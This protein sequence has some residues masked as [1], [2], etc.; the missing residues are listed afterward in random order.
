MTAKNIRPILSHASDTR[1]RVRQRA[2]EGIQGAFPFVGSRYVVD[3]DDVRVH[4][5]EFSPAEHKK[6]L[7]HAKTMAE[8]I[9]GTLLLKD[10]RTGKTIQRVP[11][12]NLLQLPY[13]TDHHTFVIDGNSYTVSNQLRM[14]PGVY[15]RKRRNEDLEATFNLAKGDNFRMS[16]DPEKGLFNVE[17][18]STKIP[19]YSV[20]NKMGVSDREMAKHWNSRLVSANRTAVGK[21]TDAHI[22]KL[23]QKIVRPLARKPGEDKMAAI[24]RAYDATVL[25]PKITKRT[26]GKS[27]D[28]VTPQAMLAASGKLLRVYKDKTDY[29]ERDNMAFKHIKSVDDFVRERIGLEARGL[30]NKVLTKLER[31]AGKADL[32]RAMPSSPFT[33][34]IRQ[35]LATSSLSG[36]PT[37]IN[38]MEIMDQAVRVTSLGEGGISSE[39]AIPMEARQLHPSHVT[40][41]D[42]I[43]TPE[44]SRAGIDLR[45]SMFAAR[46]DDGN[47]YTQLYDRKKNRTRYVPIEEVVDKTV[48]FPVPRA[49]DLKGSVDVIRNGALDSAP[50]SQVDYVI[51]APHAMYSPAGNMIPFIE[52]IDGNRATM[53]AKMVTQALPLVDAETPLVQVGGYAGARE[54]MEQ[55]F[56]DVMVP[57]APVAGTITGIRDGY[58][59]MRPKGAKT[60]AADPVRIPIYDNFPLASKTLIHHTP[61][62]KKGDEVKAGQPLASADYIKDGVVSLGKNLRTAYM[63]LRGLNSNDAVV[64]S[65]TGA[66]K[67][68]S[69]HMYMN[70]MD[71]DTDMDASRSKHKSYYG[72]KYTKEIYEKLDDDGVVKPGM[73]VRKGDLLIAAVQKSKMTPEAQMLG[74]LH[75][76]LVKPYRDAG[77]TWEKEN[78]GTVVDVAKAGKKIRLTVK[79]DEPLKIGDKLSGR[80]G[81]KG[82]VSRIV[83]DEQ[84][85]QGEDGKPVDIVISPASVV[86]RVN[87]AQ[88]LETAVGRVAEKTGK[89]IV[90]PPF[91]GRNN[92]KWVRD[93]LKKHNLKDTETVFDPETGKKI[94]NVMVGPQYHYKLF[95]TTNT[96]FSA[97]GVESYDVNQQ[98]SS[99]GPTGAKGMGRL[100]FNA[101]LAHD[102]RNILKEATTLK[103]QRNDE[104]WR[105][106]QL[107]LPLPPLK[108]TFA[109]DKFGSMITG[110]GVKMNKN[111]NHIT[112]G[113]LTDKDVDL[114]SAGAVKNPLFVRA[115]DLRPERGGL[116][117]PALTGGTTGTKWSHVKLREPTVNP[118]FE[119]PTKTLLGMTAKKFEETLREE[120][121]KGI[122]ER[123]SKVDLAKREKELTERIPKT[124]STTRDNAI[125]ELKYIRTLRKNNIRPEDAYVLSKVPVVP[126]VF[127]PIL[128]GKSGNLQVS[129]ANWLYR[130]TML[131]NDLLS[132]TKD[133]PPE[134]QGDARKHLY[135]SVGALFGTREP[136]SPQLKSR[137]V[138]GFL[139]RLSGTG[140]GPKR[141][142]FQSKLVKRRMDL[143]GRGTIAPDPT[144][145]LDEIGLP[146]EMAWGMY[147]PFVVR[148]LVQKGYKAV[149]AREMI[150]DKHPL[151]RDELAREMKERPVLSNRAPSLYRYNVLA[152]YPKLVPGKTI[153]VHELQAPIMAGDFDG[154]AIQIHVP[155]TP[156]AVREA[157]R[158]TMP[159]MLITDQEKFKLTKAAPQQE[160]VVGI[161]AATGAKPSGKKRVFK[162]KA[163][164][165]AAYN[166]GEISLSTPVEIRK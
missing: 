142:F 97:R 7:M 126:P 31:G 149:D 146:E 134:V 115:K 25:D 159:N 33:K 21:K 110:S 83:P 48:A 34:T 114:M 156:E 148:N 69:R 145:A 150:K 121:G 90:V 10:R 89:P 157:R 47:I 92:V 118:V 104:W 36:N 135:D 141:G 116:F 22:D 40:I 81:N 80:Y 133:L 56:G 9:R 93:E 124:S 85:V 113:P 53:G 78:E 8:P 125:K 13:L 164:A 16:M 112:L 55:E 120:G 28:R 154:D 27:F 24:R 37:Q 108:T 103:S 165:M 73:K 57:T 17:Y 14:K 43:R 59:Y 86:S 111:D 76:S 91:S 20:L 71:L 95:K 137:N 58:V 79:V 131:A 72:N 41:L 38:P 44:S 50:A 29:D 61:S 70:A 66:K 4:P 96:N 144:L 152:A 42:P 99:G 77:L 130:D 15:T 49:A 87:P 161:Y 84:M 23:Y 12:A 128:P 26:L 74:R 106:Y 65:E 1:E 162:S 63:P 155:V 67:M 136:D 64:V 123:L 147:N 160:S 158:M 88:I 117:D 166:R 101:L 163:D 11:K 52:S 127:R 2:V 18:G 94:P 138:K 151:A 68:T 3:V 100:V 30:K 119:R 62:V 54:S 102:A 60:A 39:R 105:A 51:P 82:V 107:G 109:Y 139:S 6:A 129:D 35:F 75:K 122:R 132:K 153:R 19:L 140:A 143:S 32:E 46:D 45:T 98:P 5:K